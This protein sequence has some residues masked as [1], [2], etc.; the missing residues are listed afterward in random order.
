MTLHEG[1]GEIDTASLFEVYANSAAARTVAVSS[2]GMV[3][4][5]HGL[6]LLTLTEAEAPHIDTR[7]RPGVEGTS[8]R[9]GFDGA[10][11]YLASTTGET[12]AHSAAKMIDYPTYALALSSDGG[13]PRTLV[14]AAAAVLIALLV[15]A[16]PGAVRYRRITRLVSTARRHEQHGATAGNETLPETWAQGPIRNRHVHAQN[17]LMCRR[18]DQAHPGLRH[19]RMFEVRP[20]AADRRPLWAGR[21]W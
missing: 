21:L 5:A 1:D 3:H 2:T 14:L 8:G 9:A 12:N 19:V 10:L 13:S 6:T 20:Q 4:T 18:T 15:G 17:P 7:L 16:A 11:E